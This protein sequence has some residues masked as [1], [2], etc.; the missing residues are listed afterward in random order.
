MEYLTIELATSGF[1]EGLM[2]A[3]TNLRDKD[4]IPLNLLEL[5]RGRN[6]KV[7]CEFPRLK[8]E[9]QGRTAVLIYLYYLARALADNV[10]RIW[11]KMIPGN[12]CVRNMV[13]LKERQ[14]KS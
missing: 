13:L 2:T 7:C 10:I 11:E 5:S 4:R 9:G 1:Q 8:E 14:R 12:C 6:Y 3:L